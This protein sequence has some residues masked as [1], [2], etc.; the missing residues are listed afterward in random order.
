MYF[1]ILDMTYWER[2][3]FPAFECPEMLCNFL[4]F[5]RREGLRLLH[6]KLLVGLHSSICILIYSGYVS[7]LT[8][9]RGKMQDTALSQ[10]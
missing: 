1:S 6:K 10:D 9:G 8:A 7:S 2:Q 3:G 5:L 4:V